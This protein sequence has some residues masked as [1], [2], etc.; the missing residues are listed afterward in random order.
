M[1]PET[2][3]LLVVVALVLV[4]YGRGAIEQTF[5]IISTVV[6]TLPAA[7]LPFGASGKTNVT[8]SGLNV[9]RKVDANSAAGTNVT[10][11]GQGT[12]TMTAG[13][14]TVNLAACPGTTAAVDFTG[15]KIRT[16]LLRA[17]PANANP[18]TIVKGATNGYTGA[19]AAFSLTLDPGKSAAIECNATLVAAGVRTLDLSGTGAQQLDIIVTSGS[20]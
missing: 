19:G 10:K 8:H 2:F 7:N 5:S 12:I 4:A 1:T 16:I 14:A 11:V 9:S 18:I 13:A 17:N 6:E 3:G 20:N 15:D